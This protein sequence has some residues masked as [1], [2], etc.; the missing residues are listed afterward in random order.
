MIAI[1]G[2]RYQIQTQSQNDKKVREIERWTA[3][4]GWALTTSIIEKPDEVFRSIFS[5]DTSIKRIL[6]DL[7]KEKID[8]KTS[9]KSVAY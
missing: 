6:I 7:S 3:S 9:T 1:P 4:T 2:Y 5:F 8:Q